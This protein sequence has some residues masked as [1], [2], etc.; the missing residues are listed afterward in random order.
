MSFPVLPPS[1]PSFLQA[2]TTDQAGDMTAGESVETEMLIVI[3]DVN[4]HEPM[5][6]PLNYTQIKC[7]NHAD[8]MVVPHF[9]ITV[10]VSVGAEDARSACGACGALMSYCYV[11]YRV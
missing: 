3:V 11:V 1:L 5:F 2:R 6:S 8:D 7:E 10:T 9:L 4:D